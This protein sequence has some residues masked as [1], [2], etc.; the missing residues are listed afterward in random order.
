MT[1]ASDSAAHERDS[2]DLAQFGYK[3][4]LKRSLG[5]VQLVRGRLQLHLALH[6]H[7]HPVLLW[8]LTR[9]AG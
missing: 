1:T 9:S 6:R 2:A 3:Q 8:R 5:R 4:E 7:L